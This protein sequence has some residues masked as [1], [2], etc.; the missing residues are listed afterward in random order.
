MVGTSRYMAP[1]VGGGEYTVLADVWSGEHALA[2]CWVSNM[3]ACCALSTCTAMRLCMRILVD[4]VNQGTALA[5]HMAASTEAAGVYFCAK[6]TGST[7]IAVPQ[8]SHGMVVL[9]VSLL[10]L[11]SIPE[12]TCALCRHTTRREVVHCA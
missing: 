4:S 8:C 1:E 3:L 11:T 6:S 12:P 7:G 5:W 9:K 2:K 10:L